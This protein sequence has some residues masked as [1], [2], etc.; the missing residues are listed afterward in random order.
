[1]RI[2]KNLKEKYRKLVAMCLMEYTENK[3][4]YEINVLDAM[5]MLR[6]AWADVTQQ[7]SES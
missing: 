1:M 5:R 2:I 6:K 4:T 3:T 7:T